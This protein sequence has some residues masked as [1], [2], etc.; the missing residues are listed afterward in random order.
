MRLSISVL[1]LTLVYI[2]LPNRA[3][4]YLDPASGAFILQMI[5]AGI[6]SVFFFLRSR[7]QRLVRALTGRSAEQPV[8]GGPAT[9]G[10]DSEI[11]REL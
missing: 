5:V 11:P 7:I 10:S 2:A 8:A 9:S 4:A 3:H 6:A 1:A